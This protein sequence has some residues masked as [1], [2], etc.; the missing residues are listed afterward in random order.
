MPGIPIPYAFAIFNYHAY[1]AI[2]TN[3]IECSIDG[4]H[5]RIY[6]GHYG[7][8]LSIA[9]SGQR[10]ISCAKD[11]RLK[12]WN[13][14]SG[15]CT[16]SFSL[17][18]IVSV[19]VV[20][21]NSL[22]IGT[23]SG[24]VIE[25]D[26]ETL[27]FTRIIYS[28]RYPIR[29]MIYDDNMLHVG[30]ANGE[31]SSYNVRTSKVSSLP[32]VG[33]DILQIAG[34]FN[35]GT[36]WVADKS[37]IIYQICIHKRTIKNIFRNFSS[38]STSSIP[39]S[40][41]AIQ[42][43]TIFVAFCNSELCKYQISSVTVKR[44]WT[45]ISNLDKCMTVFDNKLYIASGHRIQR[46]C[47]DKNEFLTDILINRQSI[48]TANPYDGNVLVGRPDGSIERVTIDSSQS[49]VVISVDESRV[50]TAMAA[51]RDHVY[52]G[53]SSGVFSKW[54]ITSGAL[55]W[56]VKEFKAWISSIVVVNNRVI[57]AGG[58]PNWGCWDTSGRFLYTCF[59]DNHKHSIT[60]MISHE[61]HIFTA[62][63]DGAAKKWDFT[64]PKCIMTFQGHRG[65][66][67]AIAATHQYLFTASSDCTIMSWDLKSGQTVQVYSLPFPVVCMDM[68]E[69]I[70][71]GG[72]SNHAIIRFD[73]R[74]NE[75]LPQLTG[76][77]GCVQAMAHLGSQQ[78]LATVHRQQI[79]LWKQGSNTPQQYIQLQVHEKTSKFR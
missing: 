68:G 79:L 1:V 42:G 76:T 45:D 33:G 60:H 66:I 26:L 53:T 3:I 32:A 19:L 10:M 72:N 69:G 59:Q 11:G 62:G 39:I 49:R 51:T 64:Q 78:L 2:E 71:Y 58:L 17:Q 12:F 67:N 34:D 25:W 74:R 4:S 48:I 29:V 18:A 15:L 38:T 56:T 50:I 43:D 36:L 8:V 57:V 31:L 16:A 6:E 75:F 13:I 37:D 35:S 21:G 61:G 44:S 5:E 9:F 7:D 46:M 41:F 20:D 27:E 28:H 73:T 23:R 63:R 22:F 24:Q 55:V 65:R 47:L 40:S 70:L 77:R 52:I 30:C 54:E 14:I